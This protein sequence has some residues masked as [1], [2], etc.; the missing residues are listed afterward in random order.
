[1][2]EGT[3]KLGSPIED[4]EVLTSL[5]PQELEKGFDLAIRARE[6]KDELGRTVEAIR[7][8]EREESVDDFAA[9]LAA[10][11]DEERAA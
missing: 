2:A 7:K 11:F 4:D 9:R 5:T 1:M 10:E 8:I 6:I 3:S